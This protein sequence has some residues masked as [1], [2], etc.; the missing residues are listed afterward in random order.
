MTNAVYLAW[1]EAGINE[2][3]VDT[4]FFFLLLSLLLLRV[5]GKA[6]V[7]CSGWVT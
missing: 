7:R 3:C 6:G 4:F 1:S 5:I 2:R